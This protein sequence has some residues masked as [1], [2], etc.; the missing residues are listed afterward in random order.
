[1]KLFSFL[2]VISNDDIALHFECFGSVFARILFCC[3]L[4][5]KHTLLCEQTTR[6]N[7]TKMGRSTLNLL[8][9]E[10][11]ANEVKNY[12]CLYKKSDYTYKDKRA[13]HNAWIKV[14]E[15]LGHEEGA[16]EKIFDNLKKDIV[17]RR[18]RWRN[19]ADLVQPL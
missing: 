18:R 12:P 15:E 8:E 3:Q 5:A 19:Y 1:M 4:L 11:V 10:R 6:F 2:N 16:A 13:K 14:E 7:Y 17:R 9:D